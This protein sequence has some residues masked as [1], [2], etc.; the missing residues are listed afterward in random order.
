MK[1]IAATMPLTL[2]AI[3][4]AAILGGMAQAADAPKDRVVAMYFHRT[5][6]CPTCQK[7]GSYSEE[8]VKTAF[9]DEIKK[10]Q[11]AFH[12]IDFED[13]KNARYTKAYNISG[14]ALIVAKI[15][16]NKVASYRNLE[17]IWSNVGDKE[18]F[19]SYIQDNVKANLP[20]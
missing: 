10:G 19:F 4:F 9:A 20:K 3:F 6:R 16:D 18:K 13:T 2:T 8:A 7:M 15:A 14:P 1:R 12:F 11:V 5:E 17:E